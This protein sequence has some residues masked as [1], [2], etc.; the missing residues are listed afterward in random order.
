MGR[1]KKY[2]DID[3][4]Q[5]KVNEYFESNENAPFSLVGLS[6]FLGLDRKNLY[7]YRKDEKYNPIIKKAVEKCEDCL[8]KGALL[9]VYNVAMVI[10][11]LKNH[12][13]YSDK[14]EIDL[15]GKRKVEIID[16]LPCEKNE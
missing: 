8:I 14:K 2:S 7:N 15:E 6:L 3:L 9:G 16:D 11:L 13:G 4:F 12:Y 10:F 5:K 1:P